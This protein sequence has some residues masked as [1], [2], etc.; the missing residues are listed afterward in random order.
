M[1]GL[2]RLHAPD[3]RD[4]NYQLR[5]VLSLLEPARRSQPWRR[6][7]TLNQGETG[8][9]VGHAWRAWYEM[10][11]KMRRPH[12]GIGAMDIYRRAVLV[13][14]WESNN[15]EAMGPESGLVSG[16]SVRAGAKVLQEYGL[17]GSYAWAWDA[18]TVADYVTRRDGSSVVLGTNWYESMFHPGPTGMVRVSGRVVGG[19]AWVVRW[20]YR[21]MGVF[22]AT[23][24]WGA[25]WGKNGE[26]RIA[27]EDLERLLR[28]DGEAACGLETVP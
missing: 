21:G 3:P 12:Q 25:S 19:H 28:E 9:C 24:S 15:A 26:F 5:R 14:E 8:T 6:Y 1:P 7:R 4:R 18:D 22:L 2:G 20:Y 23:N 11:P 16:T 10:A 27:G 17:L 13:D